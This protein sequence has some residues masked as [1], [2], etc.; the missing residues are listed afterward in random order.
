MKPPVNLALPAS[1]L[2]L[3]IAAC[4][5]VSSESNASA[6]TEAYS[7]VKGLL[8]GPLGDEAAPV[9]VFAAKLVLCSAQHGKQMDRLQSPEYSTDALKS[10]AQQVL[11]FALEEADK[12]RSTAPESVSAEAEIYSRAYMDGAAAG[13]SISA[14]TAAATD[15]QRCKDA[16]DYARENYVPSGPPEP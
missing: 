4:A 9:S 7:Q 6:R 15:Y 8:S 1:A 2:L 12:I 11:V 10:V 14:M 16:L 3:L 13:A 5:P